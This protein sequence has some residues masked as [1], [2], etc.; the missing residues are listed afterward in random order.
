MQLL[1][2]QKVRLFD[3]C[4]VTVFLKLFILMIK[5]MFVRPEDL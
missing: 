1:G 4:H 5:K 3:L 2:P